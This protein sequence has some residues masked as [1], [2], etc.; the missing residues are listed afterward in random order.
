[1]LMST[2]YRYPVGDQEGALEHDVPVPAMGQAAQHH[3]ASGANLPVAK[4]IYRYSCGDYE[5]YSPQGQYNHR[6]LCGVND[7]YS[8][9]PS[10]GDC[11]GSS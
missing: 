4:Y 10:P 8:P 9:H 3:N 6:K 2:P 5:R 1:M 11:F 7:H